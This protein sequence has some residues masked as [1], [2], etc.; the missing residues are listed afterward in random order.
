VLKMNKDQLN[1]YN[2]NKKE[3]LTNLITKH[4]LVSVNGDLF[5]GA[6]CVFNKPKGGLRSRLKATWLFFKK[7]EGK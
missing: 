7:L 5:S 6:D 1:Q 2:F 3:T 4:G